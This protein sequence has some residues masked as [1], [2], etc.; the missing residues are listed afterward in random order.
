MPR[1]RAL[2][3]MTKMK[4]VSLKMEWEGEA[5]EVAVGGEFNGWVPVPLACQQGSTWAVNLDIEP[6]CYAYRFL[7][8]GVWK[9]KEGEEVEEDEKGEKANIL[10]LEEEEEE[11]GPTQQ[12]I[13]QGD[14]EQESLKEEE[15]STLENVLDTLT[16]GNKLTENL[17]PSET[18]RIEE[19]EKEKA[20]ERETAE[21]DKDKKVE[22]QIPNK[23]EEKVKEV[24]EE[25]IQQADEET[26]DET[27]EKQAKK[28]VEKKAEEKVEVKMTRSRRSMMVNK[29]N[30]PQLL[31]EALT[32]KENTPKGGTPLIKASKL[33]TPKTGKLGKLHPDEIESPRRITRNLLAKLGPTA[34]K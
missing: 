21:E 24:N 4:T 30:T 28:K 15:V 7:V 16:I 22:E 27:V 8:D 13:E 11:E 10:I 6:G 18:T 1:V 9:I 31:K 19:F 2:P 12:S 25:T 29:E 14:A 33:G 23:V 5:K 17:K 32:P 26:A 34:Q 20:E 3:R